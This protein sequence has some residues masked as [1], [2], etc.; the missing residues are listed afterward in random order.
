[1]GLNAETKKCRHR[2]DGEICLLT[3]P[4]IGLVRI[5]YAADKQ[6]AIALWY[7]LSQPNDDFRVYLDKWNSGELTPEEITRLKVIGIDPYSVDGS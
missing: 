6:G 5:E 1:M 2:A 4:F 3:F 7:A